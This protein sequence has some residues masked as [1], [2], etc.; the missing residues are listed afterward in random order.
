MLL[1]H[2]ELVDRWTFGLLDRWTFGLVDL[3]RDREQKDVDMVGKRVW[4][5]FRPEVGRVGRSQSQLG[6]NSSPR[7][8]SLKTRT[9]RVPNL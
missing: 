3:Y 9:S 8:G 7:P 6:L 4:S 1:H 2:T 5:Y